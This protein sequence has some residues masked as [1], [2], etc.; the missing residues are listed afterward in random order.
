LNFALVASFFAFIFS[1][2]VGLAFPHQCTP[3]YNDASGVPVE[4]SI[5]SERLL[6]LMNF[7]GAAD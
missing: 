6:Y 5:A 2:V 4:D 1:F 3:L 7:A